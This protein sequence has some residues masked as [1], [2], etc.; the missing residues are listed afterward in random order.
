MGTWYDN[1]EKLF[2]FCCLNGEREIM[3]FFIDTAN[4]D[5]IREAAAM[6]IIAGV[7]TNP[8]LIA[9]EGRDYME[10]LKEITTIVD[11]PISFD[12]A[13]DKE[14]AD[15]KGYKSP[16]AG[17]CDILLA[18]NIHAG[19]IMGKMMSVLCKSRLG[20][21][22]VGTTHPVIFSS[23][24]SSSDEKFVSICLAAISAMNMNQEA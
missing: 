18:P 8:S 7:T 4:V 20:G 10:T 19:N 5:E 2:E 14:I 12:C 3:R 13:C 11:G 23:R 15:F 1:S 24:G 9:K 6:G 21:F 17:E 16:V 22:L